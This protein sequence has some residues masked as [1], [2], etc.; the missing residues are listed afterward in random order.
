MG[1][2]GINDDDQIDI[3]IV[4]AVVVREIEAVVH[5]SAGIL[6]KKANVLAIPVATMV[7]AVGS[8]AV[9]ECHRSI[10]VELGGE[11][12]KADL[13]EVFAHAG[14]VACFA[15]PVVLQGACA[16]EILVERTPGVLERVTDRVAEL[17]QDDNGTR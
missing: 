6:D 7:R 11:L 9:R 15:S 13:L 17:S 10:D 16:I 8:Q 2:A 1:I 4:V 3:V 5:Q 14:E 12:T